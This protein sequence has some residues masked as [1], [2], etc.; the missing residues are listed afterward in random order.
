MLT[1]R[2]SLG[3][4]APFHTKGHS[5]STGSW[6][7]NDHISSE[8]ESGKP[9]TIHTGK[10]GHIAVKDTPGAGR[11]MTPHTYVARALGQ[12]DEAE[13]VMPGHHTLTLCTTRHLNKADTQ[14]Y[15]TRTP[16]PATAKQRLADSAPQAWQTQHTPAPHINL[17]V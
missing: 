16:G 3:N 8:A 11:Q 7:S 5:Q 13:N 12:T 4:P 14:V 15:L 10:H 1:A 6:H 2:Q 17:P 9:G